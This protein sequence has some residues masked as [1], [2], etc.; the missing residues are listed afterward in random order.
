[1]STLKKMI[2]KKWQTCLLAITRSHKG[3]MNMLPE[4]SSEEE[5]EASPDQWAELDKI[6]KMAI[7]MVQRGQ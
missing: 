1:M 2:C 5:E 4:T 3:K 6:R 7:K